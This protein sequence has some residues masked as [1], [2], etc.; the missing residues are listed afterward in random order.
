M[1]IGGGGG[2]YWIDPLTELRVP[3]YAKDLE[4]GVERTL[5]FFAPKIQEEAKAGAPWTDRTGNARAGL[6]A[7]V[8]ELSGGLTLVLYH[9]VPYGIWL[10]VRWGGRWSIIQPTLQRNYGLIMTALNRLVRSGR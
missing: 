9:T 7:D 5:K 1:N 8:V 6:T 2:F 3:Q 10:E 4:V